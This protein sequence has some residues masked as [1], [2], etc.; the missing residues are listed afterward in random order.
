VIAGRGKAAGSRASDAREAEKKAEGKT[1]LLPLSAC[2]TVLARAVL[3]AEYYQR[4]KLRPPQAPSR[5]ILTMLPSF[6]SFSFLL[7]PSFYSRPF[8]RR[9]RGRRG[10]RGLG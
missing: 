1:Q 9:R 10:H 2:R 7:L 4:G 6:P 3:L 8:I 5:L